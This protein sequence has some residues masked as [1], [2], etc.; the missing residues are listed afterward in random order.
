MSYTV[1][2]THETDTPPRRLECGC[3][4]REVSGVSGQIG[5]RPKAV[6][7]GLVPASTSLFSWMA[8]SSPAILGKDTAKTLAITG[9]GRWMFP[10]FLPRSLCQGEIRGS[11]VV[12]VSLSTKAGRP[13]PLSPGQVLCLPRRLL[14]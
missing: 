6:M 3:V 14:N 11:S 7:P 13:L 2:R 5:A 8:G 12:A 4:Y 9:L 1:P 10:R